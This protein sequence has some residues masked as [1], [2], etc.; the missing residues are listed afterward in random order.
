MN[1][2]HDI[3]ATRAVVAN[4]FLNLTGISSS[5]LL[6][7]YHRNGTQRTIP[8]GHIE[9][10]QHTHESN[11]APPTPE[12]RSRNTPGTPAFPGCHTPTPASTTRRIH[13]D[14]LC[15]TN[16]CDAKHHATGLGE[17]LFPSR[18]PTSTIQ[19]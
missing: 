12:I 10:V 14:P 17:L 13:S 7:T 1:K 6:K 19:Q 5:S 15:Q 16:N 11:G 18:Y 2:P 3:V 8:H 4:I 9:R